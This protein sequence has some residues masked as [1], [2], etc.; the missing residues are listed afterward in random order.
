MFKLSKYLRRMKKDG[1]VS[2]KKITNGITLPDL[3]VKYFQVMLDFKKQ[4][5]NKMT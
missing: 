2:Q 4:D 5:E 1:L 3:R